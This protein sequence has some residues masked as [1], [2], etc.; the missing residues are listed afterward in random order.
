MTQISGFFSK[1]VSNVDPLHQWFSDACD[2]EVLAKRISKGE[3]GRLSKADQAF[4]VDFIS[5]NGMVHLIASKNPELLEELV[6]AGIDINCIDSDGNSLLSKINDQRIFS[7]LLEKGAKYGP[8][9][10]PISHAILEWPCSDFLIDLLDKSL[11]DD[12]NRLSSRIIRK[13]LMICKSTHLL[14]DRF[15]KLICKLSEERP[16]ETLQFVRSLNE[17]Y[18]DGLIW[19]MQHKMTSGAFIKLISIDPNLIYLNIKSKDFFQILCYSPKRLLGCSTIDSICCKAILNSKTLREAAF[20]LSCL[21]YFSISKTIS[22]DILDH[23]VLL[24][25]HEKSTIWIALNELKLND[26]VIEKMVEIG[27]DPKWVEPSSNHSFLFTRSVK[28][29]DKVDLATLGFDIELKNKFGKNALEHHCQMLQTSCIISLAKQRLKLSDQF[30]HVALCRKAYPENLMMQSFLATCLMNP[31]KTVLKNLFLKFSKEEPGLSIE[32]LKSIEGLKYI[33]DKIDHNSSTFH[34]TDPYI[35]SSLTIKVIPQ[36]PAASL[37]V[38]TLTNIHE[39]DA[40]PPLQIL[41]KGLRHDDIVHLFNYIFAHPEILKALIVA[42]MKVKYLYI[43]PRGGTISSHA[44][45]AMT[46]IEHIGALSHIPN[47]LDS[48]QIDNQRILRAFQAVIPPIPMSTLEIPTTAQ[49]LKYGRTLVL[50]NKDHLECYKFLYPGENYSHFSQEYSVSRELHQTRKIFKSQFIE[51]LGIYA[52]RKLP[53]AFD[54]YKSSFPGNQPAYVFHYKSKQGKYDYLQNLP[55]EKYVK[56][57]GVCLHDSAKLVKMGIYPDSAPLFHN[58][59]QNRRYVILVDLLVKTLLKNPDDNYFTP[60][61][62]AGRLDQPFPKVQFPNLTEIGLTDVRDAITFHLQSEN[63]H[64]IQDMR[65]LRE[66]SIFFQQ[67]EALARVLLVDLLILVERWKATLDWQSDNL[68]AIFGDEIAQ[69]IAHIFEGYTDKIH[70]ECLNLIKKSGIDWT[71]TAKQ[72]AFWLDAG[73]NGYPSWLAQ[74]KIP[75][76][77]YEKTTKVVVDIYGAKNFHPE[78]GCM[79]NGH[80]DIGLYNGPLALTEFEKAMY[81]LVIAI[82]LAE[83]LSGNL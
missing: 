2:Y 41:F 28:Y 70:N 66:D 64:F 51:P 39:L 40:P 35:L 5:K 81:L 48:L 4:L 59:G 58:E 30:P 22:K 37:V 56:A 57:R 25:E 73:P 72:V 24:Q 79:T 31:R 60:A 46:L 67:M 21:K 11:P 75:D 47:K 53:E 19:I 1:A 10:S 14:A 68:M 80:Q 15:I 55:P 20:V 33:A 38:N 54:I 27:L 7:W 32:T 78:T 69:G 76:G 12:M 65:Q 8:K 34:H 29:I 3:L 52:V 63:K 77:L 36:S 45:L 74:N 9:G 17:T 6:H 50:D 62:G 18:P 44:K 83:P 13:L 61:G 49:I 26:T 82:G 23:I 71:L 16:Q 42:Y 43:F